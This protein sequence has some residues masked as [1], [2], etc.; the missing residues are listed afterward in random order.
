MVQF[1]GLSGH[2]YVAAPAYVD[3]AIAAPVAVSHG[4]HRISSAPILSS[5]IHVGYGHGVG[6]AGHGV[7]YSG[8]GVGHGLSYGHGW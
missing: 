8:L 4:V 1:P 7:G 6:Y 3:H 5:P 2:G